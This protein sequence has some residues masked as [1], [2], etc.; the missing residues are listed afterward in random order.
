MN[1]VYRLAM[2]ILVLCC[3]TIS[4]L[5]RDI[6]FWYR[7]ICRPISPK[8]YPIVLHDYITSV[9]LSV[10]N[11][12]LAREK[13][14][15]SDPVIIKHDATNHIFINIITGL[16]IADYS[17]QWYNTRSLPSARTFYYFSG[18]LRSRFDIT[19]IW[20]GIVLCFGLTLFGQ[21]E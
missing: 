4:M 12:Y 11:L 6:Q 1:S 20:T 19:G 18:P 15:I 3:I 17:C 16:L 21:W 5:S 13:L 10:T 8:D 9:A 2:F 14:A 7:L